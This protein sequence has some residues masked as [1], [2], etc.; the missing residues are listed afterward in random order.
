MVVG[1]SKN[2]SSCGT[3]SHGL[4]PG[5]IC[6]FGSPW[7]GSVTARICTVLRESVLGQGEV[8]VWL[9]KIAFILRLRDHT[10]PPQVVI[11]STRQRILLW[12]LQVLRSL[13]NQINARCSAVVGSALSCVFDAGSDRADRSSD[14]CYVGDTRQSFSAKKV[15]AAPCT[16]IIS[17]ESCHI[18]T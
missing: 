15:M 12:E 18:A 10:R 8:A 11:Q 9:D 17:A 1:R 16:F 4:G 14:V 3:A 7:V 2:Q 13:V 6:I 5:R